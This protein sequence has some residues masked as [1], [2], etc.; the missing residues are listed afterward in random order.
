MDAKRAVGF[1]QGRG[2]A[3]PQCSP[4]VART[5]RPPRTC[6]AP[7]ERCLSSTHPKSGC[8][9]L[10]PAQEVMQ[11]LTA[12]EAKVD[13]LLQAPPAAAAPP[14]ASE[15]QLEVQLAALTVEVEAL[16]GGAG[17]AAGASDLGRVRG[18]YVCV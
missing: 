6:P 8:P 10:M 18:P 3:N 5:L 1:G 12:L 7:H 2:Q 15:A 16:R 13:R 9:S 11:R 4:R 14:A 17:V